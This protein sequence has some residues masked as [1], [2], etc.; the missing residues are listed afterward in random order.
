MEMI[1]ILAVYRQASGQEVN[2]SK[3]RIMFSKNTRTSDRQLATGI[4]GIQ[5]S[6]EHDSYLGLLLLF[7]RSKA[8]E[9]RYIKERI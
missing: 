5:R 4:L 6:M 2:V 7:G 9:L 3:S 8:K 1:R